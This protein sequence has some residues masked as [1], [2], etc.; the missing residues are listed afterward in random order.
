M[1][2]C[3]VPGPGH[4]VNI[5]PLPC[6]LVLAHG[7]QWVFAVCHA[8]TAHGNTSSSTGFWALHIIFP[9]ARKALGKVFAVCPKCSTQQTSSL[10]AVVCRELFAVCYTWQTLC[11]VQTGLCRVPRAHGK[12]AQSRSDCKHNR[13]TVLLVSENENISLQVHTKTWIH[14]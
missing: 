8:V 12:H 14:D 10:P 6:A 11:R 7:K 2:L 4:T 3:R 13:L 1:H 9:W 5:P